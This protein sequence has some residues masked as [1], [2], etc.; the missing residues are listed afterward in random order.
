MLSPTTWR[1]LALLLVSAWTVVAI[2]SR[3]AYPVIVLAGGAVRVVPFTLRS[4]TDE[5]RSVEPGQATGLRAG[6]RLV[7]VNGQPFT[8]HAVLGRAVAR[9]SEGGRIALEVE[10]GEEGEKQRL[11][12]DVT[13]FA[14]RAQGTAQSLVEAS[15]PFFM[16]VFC[17][18]LG[19]YV[20]F[21]RPDDLLAW[22]LLALLL[23]FS[24]IMSS[25]LEDP[26][27]WPALIRVPA[28][29]YK[30]LFQFSWPAWMLFFGV[31]FPERSSWDLRWPWAKWLF[32]GPVL[33]VA[34]LA[35]VFNVGASESWRSVQNVGRAL[36]ILGPTASYLAMACVSVFFTLLGHKSGTLASPDSRRRLRLLWVGAAVSLTPMFVMTVTS[37][38]TGR[39]LDTFPVWISLPTLLALSLFPLTLAYVIVIQRALDVGVVLRLGLQYALAKNAI[40]VL[41]ILLTAGIVYSVLLLAAT[42]N[43]NRSRRLAFLVCSAAAVLGLRM[44]TR[45]LRTFVDRRFFREAIDTE[46]V[47]TELGTEARTMVDASTLLDTVCRRLAAALHVS[48]IAAFLQDDHGYELALALGLGAAPKLRFA[49]NGNPIERL[50][51]DSKPLVLYPEDPRSWHH[52]LSEADDLRLLGTQLLIPLHGRDSLLGFLSLGAKSS[53]EAY[54]PSDLR[55]LGSVGSQV[56][57]ALENVRLAAM[58]AVEIASRERV[59][60]ELEIAREVQERLFPQTLPAVDGLDYAGRCRPARGVGGDYYDFLALPDGRFGLAIG[61]VS[62][63]GVS[64]ALLMASLQA[65][66]RG[67]TTFGTP[68]LG[69]LM[70]RVNR[71]VCDA[72]SAN[73]YATFFYATYDAASR[74]LDYVNAGHNAP[75]LL[76]RE[77]QVERLDRGG[78]V[79]GLLEVAVYESTAVDLCPGD[80][81]VA[82]TDGLSEAMNPEGEEWG[83][84]RLIAAV[85]RC[86][87]LPALQIVDR[88]ARMADDFVSGAPQHDDM[89]VVVA[90]LM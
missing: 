11:G 61:D 36:D 82:Y 15:L 64:A 45:R 21:R 50:R 73:R 20:V 25:S 88:L 85:Q 51:Q 77:G 7:S 48:R 57:L 52:R 6:D 10:R 76:R 2:G 24:N 42:P 49:D 13:V 39:D 29:A 8:G 12:L 83:E 19:L 44:G 69:D 1:R 62:G 56:G 74:R 31:Y 41:Q 47:L 80:L 54:S 27:Q 46:R 89:T 34:A 87:G 35:T 14:V 59:N 43:V 5:V 70:A 68:G 84:E 81:L 66:L 38:I 78:P 65:S 90:R 79:V 28:L 30:P 37:K 17:A 71:L 53:E 33:V 67:Q 72:S 23:G 60:R 55:V 58:I 86:V 26:H 63:K 4:G 18:L 22:L 75:M 3:V 40:L 9:T 32:A 16:L